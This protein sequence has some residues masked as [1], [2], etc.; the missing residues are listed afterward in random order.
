MLSDSTG[1]LARHMLTAFMTQ[2]PPDAF[3]LHMRTFVDNPRRLE[4]VLSEIEARP[5]ILFHAVVSSEAKRTIIQ[6]CHAAAV[7]QS[8]LT[9]GFVDFLARESGISPSEDPRQLHNLDASYHRRIEAIEFV[10]GHDDGLGLDTLDQADVVLVGVSRTSKTPTSIYLAQLGYRVGN[11][12]LAI[13]VEPPRQLLEL[14][15]MIVVGLYINPRQLAEIRVNRQTGWRMDLTS[16]SDEDHVAKEIT[17][18]RRLFARQG[19]KTLDVTNQAIEET[20]GRVLAALGLHRPA[21]G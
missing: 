8:D 18:S 12:A 14:S 7:P 19:W 20:A 21:G 13:E 10:L 1:N 11:V 2:F 6:R 3:T 17:W 5:G 16:Y 15:P 9:G 4:E